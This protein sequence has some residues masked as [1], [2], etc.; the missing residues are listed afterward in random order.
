MAYYQ[1]L[2]LSREPFSNTPDPGL[3]FHSRQHLEAL[4]KLEIALRLRRGLNLVIGDVGL[5]KTTL[6]RRL[7]QQISKDEQVETV[8]ILDPGFDTIQDFLAQILEHFS[9]SAPDQAEDTIRLKEALKAHL[10][11]RGKE[12]GKTLILI[13]DEGQKL[14]DHCV[15]ALRELLN[16]ETNDEKLLQIV[17]F[18]QKEFKQILE[19]HDNFNDR[20]NFRYELTPLN[21]KETRELIRFRM[22]ASTPPEA[23]RIPDNFLTYGGYL[24]VHRFTGG[25]PRKIIHLCHH[26]LVDLIIRNKKQADY[27]FVRSRI[28]PVFGNAAPRRTRRMPRFALVFLICAAVLL[29][30]RHQDRLAPMV[31]ALDQFQSRALSAL[32]RQSPPQAPGRGVENAPATPAVKQPAPKII[33]PKAPEAQGPAQIHGKPIQAVAAGETPH[34][35]PLEEPD[36]KIRPRPKTL[37][38]IRIPRNATLNQIT[39]LA[40]G[41]SDN[42][43]M[44]RVL[45]AN[46]GIRNANRIM[47]GMPLDLPVI[48]GTEAPR[49]HAFYILFST[50]PDLNTAFTK[51]LALTRKGVA[52]RLLPTWDRGEGYTFA[53]TAA[54]GFASRD[55]A[56]RF[57]NR[58]ANN[59]RGTIQANTDKGLSL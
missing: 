55:Q 33:L 19:R 36:G 16:Y 17:I 58:I 1:T 46:P 35:A 39:T 37:G 2:N 53:V 25:S 7:I 57:Q 27:F 31:E 29:G 6:S 34:P 30:L 11:S 43:T 9:G 28:A 44:D 10:F 20:I 13:I 22:A 24:A 56:A 38:W 51:A 47:A 59:Q 15:E 12:A 32:T 8:L 14:P 40:Y 48:A 49:S 26:I 4:Q 21:F 5:G 42:R 54:P 3:F 45:K 18:A 41:R 52:A 23:P 50:E